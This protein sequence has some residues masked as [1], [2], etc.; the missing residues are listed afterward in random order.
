[1]IDIINRMTII[2]VYI[3]TDQ[4]VLNISHRWFFL[5]YKLNYRTKTA[6]IFT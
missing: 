1:M 5:I 2:Y 6:T 4:N 3:K